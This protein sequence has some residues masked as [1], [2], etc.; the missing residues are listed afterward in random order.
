LSN[1]PDP[2]LRCLSLV[3]AVPSESM[4]EKAV[5]NAISKFAQV[6]KVPSVSAI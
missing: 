6:P 4:G 5:F 3:R 2:C 1:P